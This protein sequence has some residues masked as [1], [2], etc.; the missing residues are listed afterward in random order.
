MI[1][2]EKKKLIFHV[3]SADFPEYNIHNLRNV[4]FDLKKGESLN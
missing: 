1:L 4:T 2:L 3:G